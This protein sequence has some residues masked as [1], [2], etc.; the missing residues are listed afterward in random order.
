MRPTIPR[1]ALPLESNLTIRTPL[2]SQRQ[3]KLLEQVE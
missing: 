1:K 2:G 3:L